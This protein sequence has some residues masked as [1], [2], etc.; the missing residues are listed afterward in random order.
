MRY[1]IPIFC[2][3]ILCGFGPIYQSHDSQE[4]V[5]TEFVNLYDQAQSEQFR[6]VVATPNLNDLKDGE[7]VIMN[8]ST[9]KVMFR[10]GQ[11]IYSV[12]VSCVTVRR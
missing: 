10:I 1:L 11:E 3:L 5:D 2:I 12:N 7:F 6:V 9:T 4:K 8:S